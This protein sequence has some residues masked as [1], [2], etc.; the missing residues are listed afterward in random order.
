MAD[1]LSLTFQL[2]PCIVAAERRLNLGGSSEEKICLKKR[3][4]VQMDV[5]N[6]P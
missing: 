1:F 6:Q 3:L 4:L 2:L 5:V